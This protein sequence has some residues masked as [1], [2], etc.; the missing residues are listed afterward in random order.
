MLYDARY[1]AGHGCKVTSSPG[2]RVETYA[3]P[4]YLP[5]LPKDVNVHRSA[6]TEEALSGLKQRVRII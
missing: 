3:Q 1:E 4:K 2:I 5:R 6:F